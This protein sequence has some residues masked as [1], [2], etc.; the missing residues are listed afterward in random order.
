MTKKVLAA[1]TWVFDSPPTH[2][3][4][5]SPISCSSHLSLQSNMQTHVQKDLNMVDIFS[6]QLCSI[7]CKGC[8]IVL[9]RSSKQAVGVPQCMCS[10]QVMAAVIIRLCQVHWKAV[11]RLRLSH[12]R[13]EQTGAISHTMLV[14]LVVGSH[15]DLLRKTPTWILCKHY[16]SSVSDFLWLT[17][18]IISFVM[19]F[20]LQSLS[21]CPVYIDFGKWFLILP[22]MLFASFQEPCLSLLQCRWRNTNDSNSKKLSCTGEKRRE[23]WPHLLLFCS[24]ETACRDIDA[25][26]DEP[27]HGHWTSTT[28]KK[29]V[30]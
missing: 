11:G 25:F 28:C 26:C 16:I 10:Q 22:R 30:D 19:S 17:V 18:D 1:Q 14:S 8:S 12:S 23:P 21:S 4:T 13:L 6:I 5:P 24:L 7:L 29:M 2:P 20:W 15:F 27:L 9:C 3:E